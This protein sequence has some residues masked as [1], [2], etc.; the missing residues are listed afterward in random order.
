MES[1]LTPVEVVWQD[2]TND[3]GWTSLDKLNQ[4]ELATVTSIGYLV[5]DKEDVLIIAMD[6]HG[7]EVNGV[8]VIHKSL[9]K[10][11]TPL[12]RPDAKASTATE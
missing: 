11:V 12:N 5:A 10:T 3:S 4:F 1:R 6:H 9:I 7:T 2:P 8:G